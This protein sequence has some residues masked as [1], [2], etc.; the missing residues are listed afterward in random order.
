MRKLKKQAEEAKARKAQAKKEKAPAANNN[1]KMINTSGNKPFDF[2]ALD[3]FYKS[4]NPAHP[5]W[6]EVQIGSPIF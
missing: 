4:S 6:E 2:E 5:L 1:T 3:W